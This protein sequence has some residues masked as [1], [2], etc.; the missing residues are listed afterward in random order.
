MATTWPAL[1]WPEHPESN[2]FLSLDFFMGTE[3]PTSDQLKIGFVCRVEGSGES[4]GIETKS[5]PSIEKSICG[6]IYEV[7]QRMSNELLI[8]FTMCG[9]SRRFALC[10]TNF[11]TT[12][13]AKRFK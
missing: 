13:F 8:R 4:I 1:T 3:N 6:Y 9:K 5:V 11:R 2:T 12:R 7:I 10:E